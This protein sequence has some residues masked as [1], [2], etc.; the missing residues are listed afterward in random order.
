[1]KYCPE[2]LNQVTPSSYGGFGCE[3]CGVL[4]YCTGILLDTP[5]KEEQKQYILKN[6]ILGRL[7][8]DEQTV[9]QVAEKITKLFKD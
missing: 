9:N 7:N 4:Q 8:L 3:K 5:N 2:C 6:L 1:M